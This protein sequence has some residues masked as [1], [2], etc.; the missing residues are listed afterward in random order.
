MKPVQNVVVT[1]HATATQ[2]PTTGWWTY[3]YSVTNEPASRNA[4]ETFAVRPMWK[5]VQIQSP[6]HWMVSYGFEGD[7]TAVSWSV[8]DAGPAPPAW[9]GV[10]L[11]QGPHHPLPGKTVSGFVIVSRQPPA[12]LSFYAQGFDTLQTGAEDDVESAPSI[13]EE[14]VT[15]TTIGPDTSSTV[16]LGDIE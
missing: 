5:P 4:L 10:Q 11:Y 15:G 9:N 6:A 16:G 2:D 14:G 13:F 7:S 12:N 1:V 3:N 8:V